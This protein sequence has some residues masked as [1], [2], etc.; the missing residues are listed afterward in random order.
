MKKNNYLK[1]I[2]LK[3]SKLNE[4]WTF[5]ET[6]IVIALVL[7][8]STSVGFSAARQIDKAK[9]VAAKSDIEALSLAVENFYIDTG[10]YPEQQQ[11]LSCLV[12]NIC[13]KTRNKWN[14]PYI[15]KNVPLDPWGNDYVYK[16]PGKNNR[17]Y[18]IISYGKD[19]REGG[20]ENDKDISSNEN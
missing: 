10:S 12:E 5:I 16:C 8:L 3:K 20:A 14:G 19:G 15:S 6:L 4:G 1:K 17:P 11:G 13:V 9:A 2:Y 18:E 7:I